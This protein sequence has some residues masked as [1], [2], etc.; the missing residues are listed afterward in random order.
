MDNEKATTWNIADQELPN[1]RTN[2]KRPTDGWNDKRPN[3]SFMWPTL[4]LFLFFP[5]RNFCAENFV[6]FFYEIKLLFT[7]LLYLLTRFCCPESVQQLTYNALLF[8]W[9]K[10]LIWTLIW[11]YVSLGIDKLNVS[12]SY[13]SIWHATFS[14]GHFR[15]VEGVALARHTYPEKV[16]FKVKLTIITARVF[17][18][19][20]GTNIYV[21][22]C[23]ITEYLLYTNVV[24]Y[25]L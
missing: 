5:C 11:R 16:N 15:S 4:V 13:V 6:I 21:Y 17:S 12:L 9:L 25:H 1:R 20:K 18:L 8:R 23:A 3:N 2:S 19:F 22:I 7:Y 14:M 24:S 10:A